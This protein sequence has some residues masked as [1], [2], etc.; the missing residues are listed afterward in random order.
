MIRLTTAGGPEWDV[1]VERKTARI[2]PARGNPDATVE[3]DLATWES[4]GDDVAAAWTPSA[5]AACTCAAT[6]TSA[7]ASSPRP[8]PDAPGRLRF[9]RVR[10]A[11]GSFSIARGRQRAPG[12]DA[13][14]PRRHQGVVPA[15]R[16]RALA[17]SFR[18]IAVD[19]LGFGDSDKP[20]GASYEP[21]SSR[22]TRSRPCSTR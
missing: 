15:R 20:L 1:T 22:P 9:D 13:A 6:S 5:E 12:A 21:R 8:R 10:T 11:A 2:A 4:I 14:R 3:A 16:S 17:P 18:A 19:A 7:S